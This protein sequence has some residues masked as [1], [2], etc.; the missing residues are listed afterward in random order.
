MILSLEGSSSL[1]WRQNEHR[2]QFSLKP[3]MRGHRKVYM[4]LNVR[5]G[6]KDL[7]MDGRVFLSE[8]KSLGKADF[9]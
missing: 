5:V 7:G 9:E 4:D 6:T 1:D 3:A 8:S 2:I